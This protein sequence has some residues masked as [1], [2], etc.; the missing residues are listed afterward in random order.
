MKL[1][2]GIAGIFLL[3]LATPGWAAFSCTI[4]DGG[5]KPFNL[6]GPDNP[7]IVPLNTPDGTVIKHWDYGEFIP[8]M[9][10]SCT[11]GGQFMTFPAGFDGN[12]WLDL[13]AIDNSIYRNGLAFT[14][15]PGLKLRL[16]VKAITVNDSPEADSYPPSQMV[17]GRSLNTEY[18]VEDAKASVLF[19]FGGKY[20]ADK[21]QYLF[22][23]S[24]NFAIQAMAADLI[25]QGTITYDGTPV[26]MV[27]P[28]RYNVE[29]SND[30]SLYASVLLGTG[31]YLAKPSCELTNKHQI[32]NLPDLMKKSGS[33]PNEGTRTAFDMAIECN[34]ALD[35]IDVTF[36]D[37]N[38]AQGDNDYLSVFDASTSKS[39]SGVGVRLFDENGN[40]VVLGDAVHTGAAAQGPSNKRF[41]A[42]MTQTESDIKSEGRDFAG[43]VTA[44]A[45]V[46][47]TY[48]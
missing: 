4:D 43:D 30:Q 10:F 2:S 1:K 32:V 39:I 26:M 21:S 38:S 31:V 48:Y 34:G 5:V 7:I 20:N 42:A 22:D 35:N 46:V 25:K 29:N 33:M 12:V 8:S 13:T 16:Y 36:T 17:S 28:L 18:I 3:T 11:T 14:H 23:P 24:K 9:R 47:I 41:Y 27:S 40:K 44:R 37:A 15:N 6:M 19:Q 45:N